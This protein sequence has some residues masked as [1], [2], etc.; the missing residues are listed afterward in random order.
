MSTVIG[1]E[2]ILLW[3]AGN[4]IKYLI[5]E[6]YFGYHYVWCSP[7]FEAAALARYSP[8]RAQ[9]ESSDPASIYRRLHKDVITKDKHSNEIARQRDSLKSAALMLK[10]SGSISDEAAAEV[11]SIVDGAETSDWR[12]LLYVIPYTSVHG[13][14]QLVP[15]AKRASADPEYIVP[16]LKSGEFHVIEPMPC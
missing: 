9:P 13:R 10:S 8:G 16:D 1:G 2:P 14:V 11:A 5:Y 6:R 4:A 12:P 15:Y 7:V 3:S